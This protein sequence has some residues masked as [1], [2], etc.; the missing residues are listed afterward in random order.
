MMFSTTQAYGRGGVQA[1]SRRVAEILSE[2][3]DRRGGELH[4]VSLQDDGWSSEQHPNPVRY[5]SFSA[6]RGSRAEFIRMSAS[7]AWR[8]RPRLAVVM[9]TCI[10]PPAL[11]F[12]KARMTGPY[13]LVLHGIEAWHRMKPAVRAAAAG[14]SRI[15]A[16]TRFTA[17]EFARANDIPEDRF[18][19]IPL[20]VGDS[21]TA[22]T[23]PPQMDGEL[24][25][26][27]VGRLSAD[28]AYKGFDMLISAAS[29]ARAG[30]ANIQLR[31]IGDG[32]DRERL[33]SHAAS[34]GLD[35]LSVHFLGA[36]PDN[37]LRRELRDCHVFALPSRAE[38][39]GIVYLEAMCLGR[40]CIAGN[41]GGPPEIIDDGVDGFLVE[42]GDIGQ[43]ASRL[44]RFY[45]E[46]SLS[47]EM[48]RKA[49][50]RVQ[51]EYLFNHMRDGWFK[52]LDEAAE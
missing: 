23:T 52:L 43:L 49:A 21:R 9:H 15:V 29:Q 50:E 30:G 26:L 42:H 27:T 11:L 12:R 41:H 45:Q 4:G 5:A 14:A 20:A 35:E 44:V 13:I 16:T 10:A 22:A 3:A 7:T 6:A 25:V 24:R 33:Q 51:R 8:A 46:P 19:V 17:N 47:G 36:V 40:P 34:R 48:G 39:F 37:E 31:I 32:D 38:G 28:D 1:Y 2:Y 18:S